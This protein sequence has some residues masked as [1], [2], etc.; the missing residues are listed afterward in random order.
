M[1]ND[2]GEGAWNDRPFQSLV[3]REKSKDLIQ[4]LISD[5]IQAEKSTDLISG[6]GHGLIMLL[7]G[8]PS[9]GKTLTAE[10]VAEIANKPLYPVTCG[11]IG[12][13]ADQAEGYIE[14]TSEGL[15]TV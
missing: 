10:S 7:H 14:Y 15:G 3:L 13:E 6:R 12:T 2:I 4:T 1:V 5:Q 8:G 9:T 11:H